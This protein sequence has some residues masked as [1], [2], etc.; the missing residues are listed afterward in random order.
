MA[1]ARRSHANPNHV[2]ERVEP[3]AALDPY[4]LVQEPTVHVVTKILIVF[5][6]VLCVLL[7]A[8]TMAYS[9]NADRIASSYLDEK[10]ARV[11]AVQ[12]AEQQVSLS[13]E[14]LSEKQ[15]ELQSLSNELDKRTSTITQLQGERAE[16]VS[17]KVRAESDRD[18]VLQKIDQIAATAETQARLVD[19]LTTEVSKLRDN[20]L[21]YRRNEIQLADRINDLESQREV[22]EQSVRALQEQLSELR[23]TLA[24][25]SPGV[26]APGGGTAPAGPRLPGVPVRGRVVT[27]QPDPTTGGVLAQINLG[28]ADQVR[29][30]TLL[31]LVRGSKDYLGQLVIIKADLHTA[32]GRVDFQ[33][34]TGV[35]IRKDD[36]V[37]SSLR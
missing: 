12:S 19:V 21:G 32:I 14:A 20:E 23:I 11:A 4:S 7:A 8:L 15:L 10:N 28:T 9:V 36:V 29:E 1:G 25:A 27:T 3:A 2:A 5:A 37:M 22:L 6:A 34:R 16:L 17:A 33:G 24:S 13:K 30:N 26:A 35:Q 31:Y 18:A